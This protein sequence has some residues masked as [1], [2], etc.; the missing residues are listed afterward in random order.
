[1]T[2]TELA[3]IAGPDRDRWGRYLLP[4]VDHPD[5]KP[6]AHT[7]AT[8]IA[9]APEDQGGLMK[10]AQRMV[11]IGLGRRQDLHA[12]AATTDPNDK[13]TLGQIA[14]D[15]EEAGGSATGRNTG[16]AIHSAIEAVNRGDEPLPLFDAEVTAYRV[17][18]EA[19]GLTPVPELVERIVAHTTRHIAGT[20]D[21]ALRDS[22]GN[23][24]VADLK[25]L[26]V[27]TPIPTPSG[28]STMGS[29]SVDDEVFDLNG[30]IT[31]VTATSEIHYKDCYRITLDD[32]STLVADHDHQ[33]VVDHGYY[34][35]GMNRRVM[36][37]EEMA[38][39]VRADTKRAPRQLR[40]PV[41]KPVK[42]PKVD[43]PIDP[44]I[45]G[46]WLGDGRSR[47][48]EITNPMPE[49]WA[50]I[51][52]RGYVLSHD[53]NANDVGCETR[54]IRGLT[55]TL[56]QMGLKHHK[57]IPDA[58]LRAS[59]AQRVDL[60]RGLM[61]TDGTFNKARGRYHYGSCTDKGLAY[62]I[63]EL[64]NS[65]GCRAI[66]SEHTSHGFGLTVSAWGVEFRAPFVP[67]IA[68]S[69]GYLSWDLPTS[70]PTKSTRR[71][72]TSVE[73]TITV[74]T[75]C[76]TVDS[77][78]STYLA[79][80]HFIPTH[81]TGSVS[82]PASMAIQL[83]IY[84][85]AD[86][87]VTRDYQS[88]EAIPDFN[89][90]RGVI[91]HLPPG[92]PC[93]LHWIDLE[94]GRRGLEVALAVRGWRSDATAQNLLTEIVAT[95]GPQPHTAA[96]GVVEAVENPTNQGSPSPESAAGPA[97]PGGAADTEVEPGAP[98][99]AQDPSVSAERLAW[100]LRRYEA[101]LAHGV[102]KA[103]IAAQWP[104]GVAGPARSHE[105]TPDDVEA[106]VGTL[107]A[108]EADAEMPFG[109]PDP[110]LPPKRPVKLR[111]PR[112]TK[113][114]MD[115][116]DAAALRSAFNRMDKA[117]QS[118]VLTW[119]SEGNQAD[120][121]WTLGKTTTPKR[122]WTVNRA[123]LALARQTTDDEVARGWI[124][125]VIG[126]DTCQ[127]FPPGALLGTLSTTE[128][129]RLAELAGLDSFAAALAA[130]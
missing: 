88:Y 32:G 102:D 9:K 35:G 27:N 83:A 117:E 74:P 3:K 55:T 47:G 65:L 107:S 41:T 6:V 115:P 113:A 11:V 126:E 16:T 67:F 114:T 20:F 45:L 8:T 120:R 78:T 112:A 124:A 63:C 60:L 50:E 104:T 123:A 21:V 33:W 37:T 94:A 52:R 66:V 92:G 58:Y 79:G 23:L 72:V 81:N 49:I 93:A 61:D 130:A 128:A 42:T 43:L 89:R 34:Q 76:I 64:V 13:K 2:M 7:R 31:R 24:F 111:K 73:R 29:L 69:N 26:D 90:E 106:V 86:H 36:T 108:I 82:Y 17:A 84:T 25:G 98:S 97:R 105:W 15:A 96:V 127:S 19:A 54:N 71:V 116:E 38:V 1:M 80:E 100:V 39:S 129:E 62:Q 59:E 110:A 125:L 99:V 121:P 22:D 103:T 95:D 75:R 30:Q 46:A 101:V 10:W 68:K 57:H 18:L 48:G 12:L 40:I 119:Q 14:R 53:Y 56:R 5:G 118:T 51:R 122:E 109:E 44:Y 85:T 28:W 77:E 70:L 91:I 4:P 87:L